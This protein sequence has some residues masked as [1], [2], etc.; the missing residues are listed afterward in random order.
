MFI[1]TYSAMKKVTK[2]FGT[3]CP[4]VKLIEL[5]DEM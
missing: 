4:E 3:I 2:H 5:I 1:A